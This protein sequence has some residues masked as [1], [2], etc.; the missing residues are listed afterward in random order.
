VDETEIHKIETGHECL[1]EAN[2]NNPIYP[3]ENIVIAGDIVYT[4]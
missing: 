3:I 2:L 4:E 1:I